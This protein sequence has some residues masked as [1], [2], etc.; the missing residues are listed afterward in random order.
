M[1]TR[2]AVTDKPSIDS[3]AV[4]QEDLNREPPAATPLTSL[5]Y[6]SGVDLNDIQWGYSI[7]FLVVHAAALLALFPWFFSW[8]GVIAFA[9]GTVVFGQLGIPICYHRLLTHRSF[10]TPKWFERTLVTFALCSAQETPARWVAWH[11]IHHQHSDHREDMHSPLVNFLWSHINWLVYRNNSVQ[12]F[13]LYQ[14]YARDILSDRY[15]MWLEK[16]PYPM[17]LFYVGHAIA[18]FLISYAISIAIFGANMQA[19]QMTAS[20]FV[21]GVLVRTVWVW[22]ITWSVNSL[23]HMFGYRNYATTDDSRN[24]WFVSLITGGEGWHNNHHA[25]QA[26][27]SVQHRW[28]E[29]DPNYYVI[30]LFGVC[31]LA[32]NIVPPMHQRRRA[33]EGTAGTPRDPSEAVR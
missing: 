10:K 21:W 22:H 29:F 24:N 13:S 9:V 31:G 26:S 14:K 32:T 23:S 25:D 1:S 30:Q 18:F 7:S 12:N 17:T 33:T 3:N 2:A 11:R 19:F 8:A 15:Y 28:W 6:P 4:A 5:E 20:L 27:A 16:V